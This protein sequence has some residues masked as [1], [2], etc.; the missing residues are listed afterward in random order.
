MFPFLR[1]PPIGSKDA[2]HGT[3]A[4]NRPGVHPNRCD[5][6]GSNRRPV[7]PAF[8]VR[9]NSTKHQLIYDVSMTWHAKVD[10]APS[11]RERKDEQNGAKLARSKE[12]PRK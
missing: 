11:N 3:H 1:M 2:P 6:R 12:D 7:A 10:P 4:E 8:E 9:A 5:K